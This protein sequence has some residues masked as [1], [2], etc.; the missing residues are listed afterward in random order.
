MSIDA[1]AHRALAIEAN[2]S[3][4]DILGQ[5]LADI[6]DDDA[7]EM[8]RR[9]YAAAYHWARAERATV[10]NEARAE[11]LLAKIWIAR[12]NGA[13][14]LRHAERCL[15][16][17]RR[18]ELADFDLAYAY[19]AAARAQA[20]LDNLAEGRRLRDLAAAVPIADDADRAQVVADLATGPWFGV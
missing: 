17:C 11:W 10:A 20:C 4:W 6:S 9:A 5:P 18:G 14:A 2:N 8:T 15:D 19:E 16:A 7:E 3:T 13:I 12:S 1:A